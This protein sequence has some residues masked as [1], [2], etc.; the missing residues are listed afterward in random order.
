MS[1]L[2][3]A[4]DKLIEVVEGLELDVSDAVNDDVSTIAIL[5]GGT[6]SPGQ[7]ANDDIQW[8]FSHLLG[9]IVEALDTQ[10]PDVLEQVDPPLIDMA[11]A[12]E[13]T[14]G[15]ITNEDLKEQIEELIS[16]DD[17][18]PDETDADGE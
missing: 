18:A 10:D 13:K 14:I 6:L 7:L 8:V 17:D 16:G 11:E 3:K 12:L 4:A 15:T 5:G 2:Q 1:E 9:D